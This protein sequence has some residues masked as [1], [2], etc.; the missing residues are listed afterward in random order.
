MNKQ[1]LLDINRWVWSFVVKHEGLRGTLTKL[2]P[3]FANKLKE[4]FVPPGDGIVCLPD[5]Q[6]IQVNEE[7]QLQ[8][9][10]VLPSQVI[11]HFTEKSSYRAI[12]NFC[13]CRDANKCKDYPIELG[14]L[15][16]GEAARS[17]HSDIHCSATIEE[18]K[19]HVQQWTEAGLVHIV[20]RAKFDSVIL[21]AGPHDRLLTICGCCPCCCIARALPFIPP[22][23]SDMVQKMP[24][25]SM[26]VN[27]TCIGCGKC[28]DICIFE[29]IKLD[30]TKAED[31][32]SC[33]A[34]GRCAQVCPSDSIEISINDSTYV[35][36]TI[37]MLSQHIDVT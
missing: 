19:A 29:G 31:T 9:D 12:M 34:C 24:G 23:L 6:L 33:R 27:D 7:V 37:E 17:I 26:H 5:N 14:C 28:M 11:N 21:D 8:G 1:L 36:K 13:L 32:D 35:Q 3:S 16:I 2:L 22:E 18:A 25:V 4:S 20:G 10:M 30:G 15:F